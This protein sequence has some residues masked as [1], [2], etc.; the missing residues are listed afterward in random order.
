VVVCGCSQ[1]LQQCSEKFFLLLELRDVSFQ[2]LKVSQYKLSTGL[3]NQQLAKQTV[4]FT[5][6]GACE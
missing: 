2:Y 6:E 5:L 4:N 1:L 3:I